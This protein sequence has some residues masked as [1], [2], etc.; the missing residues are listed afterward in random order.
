MVLGRIT[1]V[2]DEQRTDRRLYQFFFVW[3]SA[4]MNI[5]TC[6]AKMCLSALPLRSC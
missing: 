6:V 1:P 4:N 3:F 5:L 2:P